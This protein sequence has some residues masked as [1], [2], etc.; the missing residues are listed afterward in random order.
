LTILG[1]L[2]GLLTAFWGGYRMLSEVLML[3]TPPADKDE[4]R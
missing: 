3:E 2:F 4:K 1:L